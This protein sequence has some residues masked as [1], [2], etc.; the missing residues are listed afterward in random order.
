[1]EELF[2]HS[3]KL[4]KKYPGTDIGLIK[5]VEELNQ[6]IK[7]INQEIKQR[8]KDISDLKIQMD[9]I[10]LGTANYSDTEKIEK[11]DGEIIDLTIEKQLLED[12]KNKL[13]QKI[14]N[15]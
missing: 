7:K 5:Q 15:N 10:N 3:K 13:N 11:L 14:S 1:M 6:E 2:E 12:K 9:S 8:E 4:E